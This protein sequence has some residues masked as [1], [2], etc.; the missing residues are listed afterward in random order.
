VVERAKLLDDDGADILWGGLEEDPKKNITVDRYKTPMSW[1]RLL[2]WLGG[3]L[4]NV[5][6]AAVFQ[7]CKGDDIHGKGGSRQR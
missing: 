3:G 6:G 2:E 7:L 1:S 5:S 4:K